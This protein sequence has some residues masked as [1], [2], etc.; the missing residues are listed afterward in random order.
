M[1]KS[2]ITVEKKALI[3]AEMLAYYYD[4]PIE[5][6]EDWFI[7]PAK[8]LKKEVMISDQQKQVLS[9]ASEHPFTSIESGHSCSK[10]QPVDLYI[11]TPIGK[12]RW[13]DLKVGDFVFARNGKPTKI[14]GTFKQG[15]MPI[16]KIFFDDYSHTLACG[17]HLW[18][19][20]G[21]QERRNK[22]DWAIKTTQELMDIG[23]WRSNGKGQARQF[24]LPKNDA[25]EFPSQDCFFDPYAFGVWL[26]DGTCGIGQYTKNDP[27]I[28]GRIRKSGIEVIEKNYPCKPYVSLW[29]IKDLTKTLRV[30]GFKY[31]SSNKKYIPDCFKYNSVEIRHAVLQGLMDTDGTVTQ[32]GATSFCSISKRLV[33]DVAWLARSL[34]GK[35]YTKLTPF[36]AGYK[37]DGEYIQC[38]DCYEVTINMPEEYPP[39]SLS[40]KAKLV[41]K[42]HNLRTHSRWID[43]IEQCGEAECMCISVEDKEHLYLTNDFIVTHNST[44][45]AWLAVWFAVTRDNPADLTKIRV[46]ANSYNQLYDILWPELKRWLYFSPLKSLFIIEERNICIPKIDEDT[47]KIRK[48]HTFITPVSPANPDNLQGAHAAHL[49]WLIDEAFGIQDDLVWETIEGSIT[50]DDNKL[51]LAG[52]HTTLSGYV[53]DTFHKNKSTWHNIRLSSLDSPFAKKEYIDRIAQNYGVNS[54]VYRIRVLGM[55]PAGKSDAFLSLERVEAAKNRIVEGEGVAELGVDPA[56][57]GDDLSVI[58]MR[59]GYKIFPQRCFSK[60]D[61]HQL[62]DEVFKAVRWLREKSKFDKTIKIKI[63]STGGHGTGTIDILKRDRDHNIEVVPIVYSTFGGDAIYDNITSRM[64]GELRDKIDLMQLPDDSTLIDELTTRT[65]D[66]KPGSNKIFIEP[67]SQYKKSHSGL[68]PDRSDSLCLCITGISAINRVFINYIT[69]SARCHNALDIKW[70]SLK[71]TKYEAFCCLSMFGNT[72]YG[73]FYLYNFIDDVLYQ[74]S[75]FEVQRPTPEMV[76]EAMS[77]NC[78]VSLRQ[79]ENVSV[80]GVFASNMAFGQGRDIAYRL[81]RGGVY[82]KEAMNFDRPGAIIRLNSLL[83]L[84]DVVI[85]N[86]CFKTDEQ[87]SQ[88]AV[89]S[90]GSPEGGY[91]YCDMLLMVTSEIQQRKIEEA[92][93]LPKKGYSKDPPEW[94]R[95][96]RA[97]RPESIEPKQSE[98]T[99]FDYLTW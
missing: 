14:T 11:D 56:R 58:T 45:F 94:L 19:V 42:N 72:M 28:A 73:A 33:E 13:G 41:R 16:Y 2:S 4:H 31:I 35:A 75:E 25:V 18:T 74:Y 54:D 76:D 87:L 66:Y 44:T 95:Q 79:S 78:K 48:D 46:C 7:A 97:A 22:K 26:G 36:K 85:S 38:N 3:D 70:E 71:P 29:R 30:N 34:G 90:N 5:F 53:H 91:V 37:K 6:C 10:A 49:L 27:E 43:S 81:A 80:K 67:K 68:S 65:Y 15:I 47:G 83:A 69:T 84:G 24:I 40:R 8:I 88:W 86:D 96:I 51:I 57:F 61:S 1:K 77:A 64:W 89:M 12:R 52:Q 63:D 59:H 98:R 62:A 92:A 55:E 93:T 9:A 60:F 82:V 99:E 50:E 17:D 39:F 23:I 21:R 20:K 32:N